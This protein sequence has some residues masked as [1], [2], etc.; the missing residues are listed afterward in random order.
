MGSSVFIKGRTQKDL[1][2]GGRKNFWN[3]S[4]LVLTSFHLIPEVK[5]K[6]RA[7]LHMPSYQVHIDL[8][9]EIEIAFHV[10]E[11]ARLV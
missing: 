3:K 4:P 1:K 9:L 7:L 10:L 5:S 6:I 2:F 11:T 8:I